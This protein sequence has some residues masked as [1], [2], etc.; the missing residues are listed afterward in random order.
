MKIQLAASNNSQEETTTSNSNH[1]QFKHNYM[2][3]TSGMASIAYVQE[4]H[5]IK[6]LESKVDTIERTNRLEIQIL[7]DI[8]QHG[9]CQYI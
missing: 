7:R 1:T 8:I 3:D 4:H 5:A 6:M 9:K 2:R